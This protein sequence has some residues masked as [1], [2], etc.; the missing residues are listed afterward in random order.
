MSRC[1]MPG[2]RPSLETLPL[3]G[4]RDRLVALG[5]VFRPERSTRTQHVYFAP[6]ERAWLV[7]TRVGEEARIHFRPAGCGCGR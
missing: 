3:A 5:A 4:L 1:P 7:V 6:T 2:E